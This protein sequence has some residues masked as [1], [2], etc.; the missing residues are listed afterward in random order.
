[1]ATECGLPRTYQTWFQL[2]NLHIYL[3][4]VRF[5]ALPAEA[6]PVYAQ[7]LINHFF[8]DA[9]SRMRERF[10]VQ[11]GR[12]V[13]GYMRDMHMQHRGAV[14]GLDEGLASNDVRLAQ[15]LWRNVW[16]AGWGNVAGVKRKVRGIDKSVK[17]EDEL[18]EGAPELAQD[19][20]ALPAGASPYARAAAAEATIASGAEPSSPSAPTATPTDPQ[21]ATHPELAF[22]IHLARVV[23]FIRAETF[24]LANIPDQ[25]IVLG[26][27][28]SAV[29]SSAPANAATSA[30]DATSSEPPA[31]AHG[32]QPGAGA[33]DAAAAAP[34]IVAFGRI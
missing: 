33:E 16:G 21:A 30:P 19:R 6:G 11:T 8:I 14:L 25:E 22:P 28:A 13:K 23:R 12:L 26:R 15:A 2:T 17:G 3:M 34:S 4:L 5:R 29:P 20:G 24:R 18:H 7:E 1:M 10:G 27:Q 31:A 9:E 32:P